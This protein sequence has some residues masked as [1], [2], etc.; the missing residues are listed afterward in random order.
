MHNVV[1]VSERG[2]DDE[3]VADLRYAG[4][5]TVHEAM[6]RTGLLNSYMRPVCGD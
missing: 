4:V 5:A 3:S 1:V 2:P 6:N